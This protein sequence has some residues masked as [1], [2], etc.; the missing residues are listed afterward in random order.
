VKIRYPVK[1]QLATAIAVLFHAIG[2]MG[3]LFFDKS[4]FVQSTAG[5]LLLMLILLLWTQALKNGYF[6][7]FL[8][9]CFFVGIIVEIIGVR[10]GV[11]FGLYSY[12]A[13]MG[14]KIL[15]VPVVLGVNWFMVIYCSGV[16]LNR[17]TSKAVVVVAGGALLAV[18]YD[19]LMEPAA[20]KLGYWRWNAGMSIP[21]YNYVCWFI[22]AALLLF[23]FQMFKFDKRN[24][25]A[26]NL[27]LIQLIFFLLL[28]IFL[29]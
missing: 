17:L 1:Y 14:Y 27:L 7:F 22:V 18:L 6:F 12:G 23:V 15:D 2:L 5:N 26:V 3:I 24:K 29:N 4:F 8:A 13:V 20:V 19:W 11:F 10:T 21:V 16:T 9:I 28:R 25:F